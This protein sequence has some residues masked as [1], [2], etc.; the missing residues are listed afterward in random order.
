MVQK[1]YAFFGII[2]VLLMSLGIVSAANSSVFTI[3]DVSAPT[4]VVENAGS[5][6]FTF[7]LTYTGSSQSMNFSFDDSISTIGT[8][9]IPNETGFNGS[10]DESRIV[11]G[12]ITG[13]ENQGGNSLTVIINATS[14]TGQRD[15]ESSF[16]VSITDVVI[17]PS[18]YKYCDEF[19][20][21][22]GHLEITSFEITNYG[23]GDDEEWEYL[24]ELEIEVAVENTGNDN[25]DDVILELMILDDDDNTI[26]RRKI[27]LDDDEKD[28]GR[29]KDDDEEIV[30]FKIDELPIDLDEGTYRIY[31]RVYDEKNEDLECTSVSED[32]NNNDET[33]FEFD[34]TSSDDSTIIVKEDLDNIL[35]SCGDKDVEVKFMVYNI[36][37]DDEE[38]VLVTLEDSKLGI[39]EKV[40]IDNLRDKKGKE[41]VFFITIPDELDKAYYELDIYTYYDYD[42]DEDEL[43]EVV[44]YGES[45]EEEGDDFSI[46]LEILSCKGPAPS[47]TASLDSDAKV[48]EE[49][50]ITASVMNNGNDNNFVVSVTEFEGWAEL[51]SVEPASLLINEDDTAMI[52]IKLIPTEGGFQTLKVNAI[53][54][55]EM[56]YQAVSVNIEE[57]EGLF[58]NMSNT[59]LYSISGVVALLILVFLVLI[60]RIS[61]RSRKVEF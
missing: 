58:A 1:S 59:V 28:L 49:L 55:G 29:I 41:V 35:A 15:D 13:F 43:N 60:I 5:F 39:Y 42:D 16:S 6:T 38:K 7:N 2:V 46:G 52:T 20:G 37:D 9:S 53:V 32:F 19:S 4:S 18:E 17:P 23:K 14:H 45:S 47:I 51:V 50:I 24:D 11:T 25:I 33:Y 54:D 26:T 30:I 44:A 27:G 22:K 57:K 36:G 56:N 31:V 10:I 61:R 21:D 48:G 8:V 40:V 34:I 12:T 3:A